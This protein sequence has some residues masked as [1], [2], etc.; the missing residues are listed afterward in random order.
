MPGCSGVEIRVDPWKKN[1]VLFWTF[2]FDYSNQL[3]VFILHIMSTV[4]SLVESP[5]IPFSPFHLWMATYSWPFFI[6]NKH[7]TSSRFSS[8]HVCFSVVI[9]PLCSSGSTTDFKFCWKPYCRII[10]H[11]SKGQDTCSLL[12]TVDTTARR[13]TSSV[14]QS[15]E[16]TF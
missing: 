12:R 6:H 9:S 3:F 13:W 1:V 5:G 7:T 4:I 10:W 11:D 15:I 8:L 2:S 16:Q 14:T